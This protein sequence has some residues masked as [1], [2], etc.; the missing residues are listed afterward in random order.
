MKPILLLGLLLMLTGC[1]FLKDTGAWQEPEVRVEQVRLTGLN[2][3]RAQFAAHFA[4]TNPNAYA[5]HLGALDYR[6]DVA[7][8]QLVAGRQV[9]GQRLAAGQTQTVTLPF[10]V[11]FAQLL[12]LADTWQEATR[13]PYRLEAGMRFELPLV[14]DLRV[15]VRH[16]GEIPRPRLPQVRLIALEQ[17]ALSLSGVSLV[18]VLGV[19]NLNDFQLNIQ[20]LNY[21]LQLNGQA[22]GQGALE[23]DLALRSEQETQLRI[24]L[25]VSSSQAGRALIESLMRGGELDYRIDFQS[26]IGSTLPLLQAFPFAAQREGQIRLSR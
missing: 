17:E 15:P 4:V 23:P 6:L 14:G 3:E 9:Q 26:Q 25:R 8:A 13:I 1:S 22:V 24:P 5:I 19:R 2:F 7:E 12:H 11:E 18:L 21:G 10:E 16:Q 20:R